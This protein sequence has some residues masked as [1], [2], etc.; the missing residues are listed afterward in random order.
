MSLP[1]G[2]FPKSK[3][4][5]HKHHFKYVFDRAKRIECPSVRVYFTNALNEHGQV[6]FIASK[7]IG[8]AVVRNK[9]K[10]IMRECYRHLQSNFTREVDMILVA[11]K[12]EMIILDVKSSMKTGMEK[13][14][15]LKYE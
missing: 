9:S 4:L 13:H 8:S 12:S 11:K 14:K 3:R 15:L 6:G 2:A 10:R 1:S 5:R 7:K